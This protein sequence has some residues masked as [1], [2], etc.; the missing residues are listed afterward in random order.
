MKNKLAIHFSF[1]RIVL[2][3]LTIAGN[4]NG[5]NITFTTSISWSAITTGSGTGGLPNS[6]DA[7]TVRNGATLTVNVSDAVCASI[8]LGGT[9]GN[10]TLLFNLNSQV[11]VSGG[12]ILGTNNRSGTITMTLGGTLNCASLRSNNNGDAFTEGTGTVQL[13][14]TNI[15][16]S[17]DTGTEFT[18]FNNLTIVGGTTTLARNTTVAGA[19]QV[20]AGA[21]LALSTFTLGSPGSLWLECGA[22]TGSRITGS[23]R[24]T[25]GG[26]V[27]VLDVAT[28]TDG[29]IISCP[30][31]L[32]A[33]RTFSIE[34]DGSTA[35][36]LTI[37]GI[38]STNFG[39]TK[40]GAGTL[41]LSAA[42]TYTGLTT[43]STGILQLGAA[44]GTTNTPLGTIGSGT[45]VTSGGALD[46][47]GFTLGTSEPL[48]L[49]GTGISGGGALIN[50]SSTAVTYNGAILLGS[51]SSIA[52]TGNITLGG[53][54]TGGQ[55]LTK[56]GT[57]ILSLGSS[58]ATLGGLTISDGTLT[59]TSGTMNLAGD[60]TNNNVFTHNSGIVIFNGSAQ[61]IGGS[62]T[63]TFNN[64]TISSS[65]STTL[66]INTLV[67]GNLNVTTGDLFDLNTYTCNRTASGGTLTVAGTLL[68]GG[69]TGGQGT[70]NFPSGFTAF[71]MT[72]GTV[73][74]D[75]IT[76]GQT[77]YSTP[78]YATLTLGN[79]SGTQN[80]GG[81]ITAT[82]LNNNTNA[83]DI[84]NLG[85]STL[86]VTTPNNTGTI[87]T[88]NTSGTP[89]TSGKTWGGTVTFDGTTAQTIP[90][91]NFNNLTL[92]NSA[93][94]SLGGAVYISGTI[95]LTNGILTTTGT[96]L[97][98]VT[99]TSQGAVTGSSASSYVNG[100]LQWTLATGNSY[101]FPVGDASNYRPFELNSITCSAPVVKVT[102]SGTGATTVDGTTLSSV[103]PRNWYAQLISGS[104]TTATVQITESALGS[105]NVVASSSSQTGPYTSKGGNDIGAT[106]T[107]D[108]AIPYTAS[109]YFAIGTRA[110]AVVLSDNGTQV[111]AASV[112]GGI[113]NVV[114]HQSALAVSLVNA[115]LTGMTCTTAGTYVSADITNLKVWYQTTNTFNSATA[116]LLS[117]LTTPGIAGAKTFP[118]FLSQTIN[119]GTTGYIFITAD[120]AAGATFGNTISINSL[121][122]SNFTFTS[123]SK[124]G[125]TTAGGVQTFA[126]ST[127]YNKSTG[128]SALQILSN[129]GTNTDGTGTQPASFTA[130]NQIF[131][132]YNGTTATIGGAW[133]VSGTGSKVVLGNVSV[134]AITFTVPS[135]GSTF[136]G[137]IDIAAASSGSN[138]LTLQNATVPTLG[139]LN[140]G[141]TVIYGYQGASQTVTANTYGNLT[142]SGLNGT[143]TFT[144][145]GS[146][147]IAGNLTVSSG[148]FNLLTYTA[149]RSSAGGT[150][151]VNGILL[152]GGTS[153]GQ[154]GSNFP[155]NFNTITLTGSTVNYNNATGGQTVY[156]SPTYSTLIMGN[157][158]G[159]QT[160]G[161]NISTTALTTTAG[162][163]LN[164][165]TYAL[166]STSV[167]N[168]GIIRTQN[169]S[170]APVPGGLTW[171]GT[172]Q[173]DAI[174]GGQR[175]M[176]GTYNN[177]LTLGNTSGTQSA[178]GALTINGAF[179]T[180]SGGTL[181]MVTYQL[182]LG[183]SSTLSNGGTIQTQCTTNP[184][185]PTGKTWAGTVN[186]NGSSLQSV[187]SGTY[188]ALKINNSAGATLGG[189]STITSL[190]IGDVT[191]NSIF[192][193]G[194]FVITTATTLTITSG[195]Y[196]CTT[197][198]F[199]W[200]SS[201]IGGTVNYSLA[202]PQ[203]VA[204]KVYNNLGLSGGNIKT[205][206]TG[207]STT[208]NGVLT[209][210][211]ST[212]LYFSATAQTL[213]L[214]GTGANTLVSSGTINI[215]TGAHLL[216][217]AAS[218]I[219]SFGTLTQGTSSTVEYTVTG[220]SQTIYP[221]SYY[222]LKLDNTSGANTAGGN[223]TVNGT[224]TTVA[225]GTLNMGTNTLTVSTVSHAGIL[226]TQNTTTTPF[227][228]SKTWGGTVIF[229]GASAQTIPASTF[230]NLTLNN[231]GGATLGAAVTVSGILT[232]TNGLLT[233]TGTNL[234]S[235]ANN[236]SSAISGGSAT[237]FINGPVKWTLPASLV[238]GSTYNFPVGKGT[239]YLPFSLVN[240]T[241]SGTTTA[242]VEAYNAGS[243]GTYDATLQA[244]SATEYWSLVTAANFTGSSVSLTRQTAISPLDA[245]GG[246][247]ALTGPYTYLAGTTGTNGVANSDAIGANR[248]FTL[249]AKKSTIT[250]ITINGSPFCAG[251]TGVSVPFTYDPKANFSGATF[252]AQLSDAVG[253]FT[254]PTTFFES[255]ASNGTGSQSLNVTI[256]LG[257]V[258]GT[259][260]RIRIVSTSPSVTGSDNGADLII[261]GTVAAQPGTIIPSITS[262][263]ANTAGVTYT[264][265]NVAGVTYTW[266]F[267]GGWIQTGGGTT[268][269][270]TVTT[271]TASG[272]VVVTP[273]NSCG[274]GP[275]QTLAVSVIPSPVITVQP[276]TTPQSVCQDGTL[277][278]LS[279]T[280]TGATAYQWYKNVTES[281]SGGTLLTGATTSSYLPLSTTAGTLY[282]YCVVS[283][284]CS[285]VATSNVSGAVTVS[286]RSF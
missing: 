139:T 132:I 61:I 240:P 184:P 169:T 208:V 98:W 153:G 84:L 179:T 119:S 123:A 112:G 37:S 277:T 238:S 138:T 226:R 135:G 62:Y 88:Q 262:P 114:L 286:F 29:A 250:T 242:Q 281:N 65:T 6:S 115:T 85:T 8:Q 231:T 219:A 237:S 121:I 155:A 18:A 161:G 149:N 95:T 221:V 67:A 44:G 55:N 74:Y 213:A 51:A 172:V 193:D 120:V 177:N 180:T 255:V 230:S 253:S 45:S 276:S 68:L 194:A 73:N 202:G 60:L 57:G 248:F 33:T 125:S 9:G 283:G 40:A 265:T 236:V 164:M 15:L 279:V 185:I 81:N 157:T 152:L 91:S 5:A 76:G 223:L 260:Y 2:L 174:T 252:T 217:I 235:V 12:V 256:P 25:L 111:T 210:A 122:T 96:N 108:A 275:P 145:G 150:L 246:C 69:T 46:L 82:V 43:I 77:I 220:G 257:T 20:K 100:P 258:P 92:N 24:L 171:G 90:A 32:G 124:S 131:T 268:N 97:L 278:A 201:S 53:G 187:S 244:I 94:A 247:T 50:S 190:T 199:P 26:N 269:S 163:T 143:S 13:T 200:G 42:N 106:I 14:T 229:D 203:T 196:N 165:G 264:V 16:A 239:I 63:T 228:A 195:I 167:T 151:T 87:R 56:I 103:A 48:T 136:T 207:T 280:A 27:N 71:T 22:T 156:S 224:L 36:D 19:L 54:I 166:S 216:Q 178:S 109:T 35:D 270:V 75:N 3:I 144:L 39:V 118:S 58:T 273:S 47:N 7:I 148:T 64:L 127:Y 233:T 107:S 254:S 146:V 168:G 17:T 59:S 10:G 99:N 137:T 215:S 182:L 271:G 113:S 160:A 206:A 209:V 197:S 117:T 251:V 93:G 49:N 116:T 129:W 198:T 1:I 212:S 140:A 128:A 154:T 159:V 79:T 134:P 170:A 158:S 274:S 204:N 72:G 104:F 192:N 34:D 183:V 188:S 249:S 130:N 243:G 222:N 86:T 176:A 70:S 261:S 266:T 110:P 272:N 162:G 23:G 191:S 211:A 267:P 133:S 175:V 66:G 89:I 214:T 83:A 241:T 285:P 80:A 105:T 4:V 189:A 38:I 141:S 218:S 31:G 142:I 181:D 147:T 78:T 126:A 245:V 205:L 232:L 259:G 52:T 263:C 21:T 234:L 186:Y 284:A 28:G 282:Y 41:L 173:Y 225:G 102:M 101:L 11:T 30:V 227:T